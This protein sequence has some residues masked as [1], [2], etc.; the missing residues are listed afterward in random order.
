MATRKQRSAVNQNNLEATAEAEIERFL[1]LYRAGKVRGAV[2]SFTDEDGRSEH[3]L[4]GSFAEDIGAAM[5][6]A[7][8]LDLILSRRFFSGD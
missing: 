4:M 5:D 2:I 7:R 8:R 3:K 1:E 6:Q